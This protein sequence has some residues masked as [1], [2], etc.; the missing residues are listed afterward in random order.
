MRYHEIVQGSILQEA[1]EGFLY[2][3]LN[4][5]KTIDVLVKDAMPAAWAH[6]LPTNPGVPLKGTSFTR[7]RTLQWGNYPVLFTA[8]HTRLAQTNRIIPVDGHRVHQYTRGRFS[9]EDTNSRASK[10]TN[11][12]DPQEE[13]V[14]GDL[15]RLHR[16]LTQ[17]DVVKYPGPGERGAFLLHIAKAYGEKWGIPVNFEEEAIEHLRSVV[18]RDGLSPVQT[19]HPDTPKYFP[20]Y[21]PTELIRR[22]FP[23]YS[24]EVKAKRKKAA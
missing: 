24:P 13:F 20:G 10:G 11:T 21:D 19:M 23:D 4:A 1:R 16:Y 7:S 22:A 2:H 15:N 3:A 12:A 14:V 17:I 9:W 6:E 5:R 8:D 18:E